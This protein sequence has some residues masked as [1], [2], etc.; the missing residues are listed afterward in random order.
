[1]NEHG[2]WAIRAKAEMERLQWLGPRLSPGQM[3]I[4]VERVQNLAE[5]AF[6]LGRGVD[7]RKSSLDFEKDPAL[8]PTE[9]SL[10]D[11]LKLKEAVI[12]EVKRKLSRAQDELDEQKFAWFWAQHVGFK[13]D[14][15]PEL[16]LPRLELQCFDRT[17]QEVGDGWLN[18]EWLYCLA[19]KHHDDTVMFVPLGLTKV[20][21]CGGRAP[22]P[23]GTGKDEPFRESH[24]VRTD[25][26]TFGLPAYIVIEELDILAPVQP[27]KERNFSLGAM[28]PE[29][30][31]KHGVPPGKVCRDCTEEEGD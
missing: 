24:H 30:T 3:D 13:K 22:E 14:P 12:S 29:G 26:K 4:L 18:V 10:L 23:D 19:Y 6:D 17:M 1:M 11:L 16:P 5:L 7:P 9:R 28:A 25:M 21:G 8:R 20:G 15:R 2:D 31:C 27:W